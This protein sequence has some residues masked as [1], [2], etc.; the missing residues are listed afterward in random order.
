MSP[1]SEN[2]GPEDKGQKM[3]VTLAGN[4]SYLLR[5][6]LDELIAE[7]V[8]KQGELALERI[9]ATE[10]DLQAILD[11]VQSLPFL[12]KRKMVVLRD[13]SA[14]K[15][16]AEAIEQ[17][18]NSISNTTDAVFY[19]PVTDK[20]TTF[21][22][23][24]KQK[25]KFEE[26]DELAPRELPKWLVNEAKKTG[27][28]LSLTEANYLVERLGPNQTMLA[29]ELQ[30]LITYNPEITRE[31]I[32]LLTDPTPQGRIFDLLDAAFGGD[33]KRA[34]KLYEEQRAQ[35]VEPQ[36]ILAMVAWQLQLLALVKHSGNRLAADVAREAGL[37]PYPVTK[38]KNL[39]AKITE[40]ELNKMV[41]E[42]LDIDWRSKTTS[43]DLDEALKTYITTL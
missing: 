8:N 36:A 30:K 16:A 10:T 26:F 11:A 9:D 39:A 34:L 37:N 2:Q 7:F 43:I 3:I 15:P 18:I 41:D 28:Q 20:R 29:S 21:Y 6:R 31:N 40:S 42:A 25:T 19:E 22:K 13:L 35:R 27:A 17:I 24:L 12:S 5:R 32:D 33:K 38:A 1:M 23:I 4:N 14:N